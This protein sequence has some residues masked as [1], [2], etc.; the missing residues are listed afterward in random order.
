[1]RVTESVLCIVLD[2]GLP[3]MHMYTNRGASDKSLFEC[4]FRILML[5][6]SVAKAAGD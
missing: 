5:A 4:S 2:Q 1:M 6:T 3:R